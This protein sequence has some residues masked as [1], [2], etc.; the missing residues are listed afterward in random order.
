LLD[1][2]APLSPAQK[3]ALESALVSLQP[4]MANP[5]VGGEARVRA[6]FIELRLGHTDRA[7]PIL[8]EAANMATEPY[9]KYLAHLYTGW[10][11][12]HTGK[13]DD[14]IAEY[15]AALAIVP[16]ARSAATLLTALLVMSDKI[17]DAEALVDREIAVQAA[18]N[19]DPWRTDLLGDYRNY[20]ALIARLREAIK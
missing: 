7:L 8:R 4:L 5:E 13:N 6:G 1:G 16:H 20:S 9:I 17:A 10:T 11:L 14:A 2:P 18:D 15:R 19:N 12:A 3:T